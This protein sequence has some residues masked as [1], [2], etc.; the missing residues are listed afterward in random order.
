M[1]NIKEIQTKDM[2]HIYSDTIA[3]YTIRQSNVHSASFLYVLDK[4]GWVTNGSFWGKEEGQKEHVS[5][6]QYKSSQMTTHHMVTATSGTREDSIPLCQ[7][8]FKKPSKENTK[9]MDGD[10]SLLCWRI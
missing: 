3:I 6:K 7:K 9:T 4:P 1:Q 5:N 2:W 10:T 8:D